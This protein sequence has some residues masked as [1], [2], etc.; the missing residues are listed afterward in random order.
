MAKPKMTKIRESAEGEDCQVRIPGICN[1]N[2][3]TTMLAHLPGGGMGM[4]YPDYLGAYACSSC[5]DE[6]DR[7]TRFCDIEYVKLCFYEGVFRTQ[8]IFVN[9]G[10]LVVP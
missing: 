5:H 7:R 6:I 4:K 8:I 2:P 1:F 10:L 3:E 9:K